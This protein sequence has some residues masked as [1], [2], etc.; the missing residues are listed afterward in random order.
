MWL[1]WRDRKSGAGR[2]AAGIPYA[3]AHTC[4][5]SSQNRVETDLAGAE[6]IHGGC[7][8]ILASLRPNSGH[9]AMAKRIHGMS[10]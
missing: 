2:S 4:V 10:T 5:V 9:E 1:S 3:G 6:R 8:L 7:L